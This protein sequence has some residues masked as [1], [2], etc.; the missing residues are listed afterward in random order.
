MR[1]F[2][3]L[4]KIILK[5]FIIFF[6]F[7]FYL[8]SIFVKVRI[9]MIYTSRIGH[10]SL[11]LDNFFSSEK[12]KRNKQIIFFGTEKKISNK[13]LFGLFKKKNIIFH[14]LFYYCYEYLKILNPNSEKLIMYSE[15]QPEVNFNSLSEQNVEISKNDNIKGQNLLNKMNIEEPFICIHNRDDKF[16][17]QI[18]ND[19]N[20]HDYR[21][22]D[23]SSM[24]KTINYFLQKKINV[25]R[26]GKKAK[27]LDDFSHKNFYSLIND[28]HDP[29]LDVFLIS[30]SQF[31]ITCTSGIA[32]LARLFR[33][34]TLIVNKFPLTVRDISGRSSESIF[35]PKKIFDK[36]K[37]NF[38]KISECFNLDY[39]IHYN[40]KYLKDKN[41]DLVDNTDEE[42]LSAAKEMFLKLKGK[43]KYDVNQ[44]KLNQNFLESMKSVNHYINL[45]KKID[46]NISIKFL[47]KNQDLI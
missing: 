7:L 6:L 16:N 17:E 19:K 29:F 9:G 46:F 20:F 5:I 4:K 32:D 38:L 28:Y 31:V 22:Y 27:D 35:I 10:L 34:K 24:R 2:Y 26:I 8:I 37:N 44:E 21:N 43:F 14:R 41:L 47:E 33:K 25:I 11:N 12:Y 3:C 39:D 15:L 30:R 40:G 36:K 1:Y 42:I 45:S 13:Y 18:V 23:I